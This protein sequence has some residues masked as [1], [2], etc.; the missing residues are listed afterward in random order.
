MMSEQQLAIIGPLE[1]TTYTTLFYIMPEVVLKSK[2]VMHLRV[3]SISPNRR[4]PLKNRDW[5]R[6]RSTVKDHAPVRSSLADF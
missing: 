1:E 2:G 5:A 3:V 4:L 6:V